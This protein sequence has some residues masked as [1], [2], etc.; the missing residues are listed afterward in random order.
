[1]CIYLIF[2]ELIGISFPIASSKKKASHETDYK[3][4]RIFLSDEENIHVK[5]NTK[6]G[7]KYYARRKLLFY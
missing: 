1:M 2:C 6:L 3:Y 4:H 7:D 5:H